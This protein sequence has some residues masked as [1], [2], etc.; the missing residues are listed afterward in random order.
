[1][2]MRFSP[3]AFQGTISRPASDAKDVPTSQNQDRDLVDKLAAKIALASS[4]VKV[5]P[6]NDGVFNI[7]VG[8]EM[9]AKLATSA[10]DDPAGKDSSI[11]RP[12]IKFAKTLDVTIGE[13]QDKMNWHVSGS[14]INPVQTTNLLNAIEQKMKLPETVKSFL[15]ILEK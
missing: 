5:S 6:A 10:I 7:V 12:P 13:G 1:M 15:S 4:D 8:D 2:N 11:K 3:V 14:D 9:T